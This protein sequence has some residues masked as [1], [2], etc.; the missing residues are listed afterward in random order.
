MNKLNKLVK[1]FLSVMLVGALLIGMGFTLLTS[2]LTTVVCHMVTGLI[3]LGTSRLQDQLP[4]G[5]VSEPK[6]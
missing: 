3:L 2:I 5:E 1:R 4:V 6:L